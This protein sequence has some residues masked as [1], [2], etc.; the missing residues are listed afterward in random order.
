MSNAHAADSTMFV[1]IG[2]YTSGTSKGVYLSRFDPES[3]QLSAP[4]LAAETRNPTFVALHPNHRFLYVANEISSFR[5]QNAGSIG[6]YKI[7]GKTG[8]LT[9][10]NEQ[11]SGGSG[12]CHLA[13]DAK[14][15][16]VLVANYGSG[17]VAALPVEAD[18][19]LGAPAV[20]VQHEGSSVNRERQAGPHA[21][22]ITADPADRFALACD[23][24][25]D[26]VLVYRLSTD[27]AGL[28]ANDPPWVSVKPGSGPR[29]LAFHP[30]EPF[31]YL[32]N[33]LGWNVT[34][35]SY[36]ARR[37]VLT[38]IQTISTVPEGF[39]GDNLDAEVQVHPS[40]K[41]LYASNR[42][43]DS[44]A[45]FSIDQKTGRLAFVERVS[46]QGKTPRHFA[47]DPTGRWMLVEN[48]ESNDIF[49]F[50]IDPKT[51]HLESAGQSIEVGSP[52][53]AVFLPGR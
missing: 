7:D 50:K 6:A 36:D 18:G 17:S 12:P 48:Q 1:Y 5:G 29:H 3:G 9:L 53:C 49:V 43:N 51:G 4:Q 42:G 16:C 32:I 25:I 33:E 10:V 39:T 47:V 20:S 46:S 34:A 30:K 11:P 31:V 22:F 13:V 40:G 19:S 38:E 8:G 26:K 15:R 44:L 45:E 2:T 35:F 52:V 23:L 37:G 27:P 28:A 41:F 14:G 21:H 24:G